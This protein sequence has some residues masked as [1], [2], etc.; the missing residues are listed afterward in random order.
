MTDG[1]QQTVSGTVPAQATGDDTTLPERVRA[2]WA[3]GDYPTLARELLAPFGPVLVTSCE[4]EAGQRVLDVAAGSGTVA[5][6]AARTGAT[7]TACDLTPELLEAGRRTAESMGVQVT[8][9]VADAASLPYADAS[10]DAVVSCVGVMYAPE[11]QR[12]ADE[13]VRVCKR[14][15]RIGLI[16]WTPHGFVG[17]MQ[18]TIR[19]YL[20]PTPG[21]PLLPARWGDEKHVTGL[22]GDRVVGLRV[23]RRE[24]RVGHF[25][26]PADFLDYFKARH[27]PTIAAYRALAERPDHALGLDLELRQ[28]AARYA[29]VDG[30][31]AW[32]Y[33]LLTAVRR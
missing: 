2:T 18:A 32:E 31:M 27:G 8:W 26:R 12:A 15:G 21:G 6:T 5:V 30:A 25:G 7:V 4:I 11:Q 28:L 33:L 19:R 14:G 24:L 10:F 1:Q 23:E 29:T 16:S 20:P 22:L 9:D 3:T 13:L 17:E